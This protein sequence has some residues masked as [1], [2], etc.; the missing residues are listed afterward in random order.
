MLRKL[1]F[2]FFLFVIAQ[3]EKDLAADLKGNQAI[4]TEKG[5]WSFAVESRKAA[6]T[7]A[8]RQSIGGTSASSGLHASTTASAA[9][10]KK[11]QAAARRKS[12]SAPKRK[13]DSL[14]LDSPTDDAPAFGS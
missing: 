3:S 7:N 11:K 2:S 1:T 6:P 10:D 5:V 4:S 12:T 8:K 14:T 13:R 9:E